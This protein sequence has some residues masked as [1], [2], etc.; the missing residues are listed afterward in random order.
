MKGL[1]YK[2]YKELL[3]EP[4]LFSLEMGRLKG[5]LTVPYNSLKEVVMRWGLAS[6]P[7]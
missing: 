2:S 4:G 7:K 5:D 6:S 3:R 1:E